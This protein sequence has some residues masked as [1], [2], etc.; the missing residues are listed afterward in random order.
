VVQNRGHFV[1]AATHAQ[2]AGLPGWLEA[3]REMLVSILQGPGQWVLFGEWLYARHSLAYDRLPSYFLAFDLFHCPARRFLAHHQ[4]RARL[5]GTGI[6]V[7]PQIAHRPFADM[8][9]L[10]TLLNTPSR[11]YRGFVEGIYLRV[12]DPFP[13]PPP[14]TARR[15][16]GKSEEE[17][18]EGEPWRQYVVTQAK[19][20]RPDFVQGIT[21]HWAGR[22]LERNRLAMG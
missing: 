19:I 2:F 4:L 18:K 15:V 21:S 20:V 7:V 11:F 6:P 9:D 16:A 12:E 17:S 8:E 3:H 10:L 22:T 13:A 14:P 5:A 1:T